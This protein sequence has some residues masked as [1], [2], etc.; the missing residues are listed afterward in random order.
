LSI[1]G[2]VVKRKG[3]GGASCIVQKPEQ[4]QAPA[5]DEDKEDAMEAGRGCDE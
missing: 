2:R 4:V 1:A 3:E 5:V